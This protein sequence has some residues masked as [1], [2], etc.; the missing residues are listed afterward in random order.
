MVTGIQTIT[1]ASLW[2]QGGS[3][4]EIQGKVTGSGVAAT[5]VGN[6]SIIAEHLQ[7]RFRETGF[8]AEGEQIYVIQYRRIKMSLKKVIRGDINLTEGTLEEGSRWEVMWKTMGETKEET[9]V[10]EVSLGCATDLPGEKGLE[11]C[12]VGGKAFSFIQEGL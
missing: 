1:E 10:M 7:G 3:S 4:Q 9:T 12:D 8:V 5:N 2:S 11:T 6:F